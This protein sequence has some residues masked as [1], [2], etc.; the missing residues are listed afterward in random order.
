[1]PAVG[2]RRTTRVFGVVTGSEN[3]RVLRSGRRLW[4]ES[5][6]SLKPKRGSG[7]ADEWPKKPEKNN[8]DA[9]AFT[10]PRGGGGTAKLKQENAVPVRANEKKSV[11]KAVEIRKQGTV[12]AARSLSKGPDKF[13]GIVYTRKRKRAVVDAKK[14]KFGLRFS[15]RQQPRKDPCVFAAVVR[16]QC[17]G[18]EDGMFSRFLVLV[19][20]A[21][22]RT[23]VEMKELSAFLLSEPL[24]GAYASRGIQFLQ[25]SPMVHVGVCQFFGNMR[26]GPSF[27]LDFSAVPHCFNYLR[28]SV[29]LRSMF[30]SFFLVYNPVHESSDV[31]DEIDFPELQNELKV[32]YNSFVREPD[33]SGMILPEV[34]KINDALSALASNKSSRLPG[35]SGQYRNVN[36]KGIQRRRTS[37]G[38]RKTRNNLLLERSNGTIT[39]NLRNGPKKNIA[40]VASNMKLRNSA[41][42]DTSVSLSEAGCAAVNSTEGLDSSSCSTNI[43][44]TESDRCYRI[45]GAVVTVEMS[46]SREWHLAVK[47]DGLTRCTLKPEKVMRPCSSNR[48][49]HVIMFSLDNGLKLEFPNRPD[50]V[51]FKDL[52][53][54]CSDRNVPAPV[55]KF[56]PVPG[57]RDVVGYGDN[58]TAPFCRPESYILANGDELS[59]AITRKSAN[60][61]MDSEDE[62][63]LSKFNAEYQEHVSEDQ[64]ELIVDALEKAS[65][66]NPDD[67]L[68]ET[69]LVNQCRDLCCKVVLEAVCSFWMRKRKQKRSSLLRVFQSN[70]SKKA[71]LIPKPLLRKRRSFK[72]Q[73]SQFGRGKHPRVLQAE[74]D[75]LEEKNAMRKFEHAKASA[76]ESKEYAVR[77]RK[78]AQSLMEN[79]DLAIYKATMLVRIAEAAQSQAGESVNEMAEHFLD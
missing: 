26:L 22:L 28:S 9:A 3:A 41:N 15:R 38:K 20:R 18:T 45:E 8:V 72:R 10:S 23:G 62:E 52:Y 55:S 25:G 1:M 31:E 75:A 53:K 51:V 59:R 74:Q 44:V 58:I 66:S 63:W 39:Y 21:T 27:S 50:W 30:R 64:F 6:E 70:Q 29:F 5:G 73:P 49:T 78:R 35:R 57:V 40:A 36:S 4:P 12:P 68:D 56:I 61:D 47:K 37:L 76:N 32:S 48:Y 33:E 77:K 11:V 13:F 67:C 65:Y 54:V 14:K 71:P 46:A 2:M 16:R 34:V 79:A 7:K 60:Y 24:C 69:Y 19:L 42:S 43:L 17:L